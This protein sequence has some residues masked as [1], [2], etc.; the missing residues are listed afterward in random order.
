[1][2]SEWYLGGEIHVNVDVWG[3]LEERIE[4]G[5]LVSGS[6]SWV[7]GRAVLF[8]E[9]YR[10]RNFVGEWWIQFCTL[11]ILKWKDSTEKQLLAEFWRQIPWVGIT[12][13]AALG[14]MWGFF[15]SVSPFPDVN[16]AYSCDISSVST[17][18]CGY[19]GFVPGLKFCQG[20]IFREQRAKEFEYC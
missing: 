20:A 1:M 4:D 18:Q 6:S 2:K 16:C 19:P 10:R 13:Y 15:F 3:E 9:K 12:S 14:K 7:N 8:V 11:G 5:T 17:Q